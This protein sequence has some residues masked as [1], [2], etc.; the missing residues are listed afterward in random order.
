MDAQVAF[1][2]RYEQPPR[3]AW[4]IRIVTGARSSYFGGYHLSVDDHGDPYADVFDIPGEH[5]DLTLSHE[6]LEMLVNPYDDR[7]IRDYP[8]VWNL[9]VADPVQTTYY[10]RDGVH[11]TDFVYPAWFCHLTNDG[12]QLD[13]LKRVR[14]PGEVLHGGVAVRINY[15]TGEY[16]R[17]H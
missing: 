2:P 13:F 4:Q 12:V 1:V 7:Y 15:T 6:V 9:E 16:E 8:F 14:T 17:F 3:G 10:T 5:T 11:L